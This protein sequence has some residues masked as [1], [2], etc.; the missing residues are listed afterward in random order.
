MNPELPR[1]R[2]QQREQEQLAHSS[3]SKAVAREFA[4]AEEMIRHDTKEIEVPP[5]IA[6]RLNESIKR[7]P[8]PAKPWW[9]RFVPGN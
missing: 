5:S 4:S 6:H 1:L 7:E 9:K 2:Q 3:D 8:K